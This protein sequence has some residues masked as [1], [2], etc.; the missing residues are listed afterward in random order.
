MGKP[1]MTQRDM[2]R[3]SAKK[4]WAWKA[5]IRAMRVHVPECDVH[6]TFF[7]SMPKSWSK[8]KKAERLG[9]P[10]QGKP[11]IDNLVKALLDAVYDDD[12]TVWDIR[13]T[14]RWNGAGSI[15]I[16]II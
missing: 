16:E 8:K 9:Q 14:K 13:A 7:I 4:Y 6:I 15:V 12:K 1:R 2:W 10:H 5:H 3:K 11:D